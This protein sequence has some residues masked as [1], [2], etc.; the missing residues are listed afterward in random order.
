MEVKILD[1]IIHGALKLWRLDSTNTRRFTELV[2]AAKAASPKTY[3]ELLA[4]LSALLADFPAQEKLINKEPKSSTQLQPLLYDVELPKPKDAFTNFY[5]FVIKGETFHFYNATLL[6]TADLTELVDIRYQVGKALNSTRV[7]AKQVTTELKEQGYTG[8]PN[9]QSSA[10]HFALYYLK[11]SLIQLF[12]SV[13]ENFQDKLEYQTSLDDFYILELEEAEPEKLPLLLNE[14]AATPQKKKTIEP[15]LNFGFIGKKERLKNIINQLCI[16]VELLKEERSPADLLV[17][18]FTSRNIKPEEIKIYLDCD[19]KSFRRVLEKLADD[20]TALTFINIE[21][22]KSFY[23]K[24]GTLLKANN[25]SKAKS[26][27]P[28]EKAEIDKIFKQVQ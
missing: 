15:A 27:D 2:K 26:F 4:Q 22:S 19:N 13:Q 20:F 25:F 21:Q 14:Q 23:S 7:L 24:R 10:A 16:Q 3:S 6:Q 9:A 18:L 28:K 5:Y 11:H 1:S 8:I 12:F 17:Q